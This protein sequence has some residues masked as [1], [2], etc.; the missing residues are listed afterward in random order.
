[1][2]YATRSSGAIPKSRPLIQHFV[3]AR[4]SAR[5]RASTTAPGALV[6]GHPQPQPEGSGANDAISL[7]G[8]AREL[9]RGDDGRPARIREVLHE[10]ASAQIVPAP[11]Q[12]TVQHGEGVKLFEVRGRD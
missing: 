6:S 7:I 5:H 11:G 4:L 9:R 3:L 1:M 8:C 12:R 2:V 10:E